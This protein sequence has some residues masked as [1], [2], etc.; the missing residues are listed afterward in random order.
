MVQVTTAPETLRFFQGQI[1]YVK[2][3]GF[4]VH[5]VSS[6][7]RFLDETAERENI[8]TH[9]IEMP[10]SITPLKDLAGLLK[11]YRLFRQLKPALVHS[12]TPKGGLLGTIAARLAGVPVVVY[13][14][15]GLPFTTSRGLKRRLLCLTETIT[16]SL[17]ERV[18]AVS[19][20]NRR[21]AI[22]MGFCA[23]GKIR[24]L[25]SGSC[26]G[27]DAEERFNPQKLPLG[28]REKIRSL[29]GIPPGDSLVLGYVGRIVRDKGIKEL[30]EAWQLLRQEFPKLYLVLVGHEEPQDLVSRDAIRRLEADPRVVFT[31]FLDDLV[32][33]YAAM[34]ILALPTYR[35]G[36]PVA[37]LE[38]AAM[39]L[40]VVATRVDGCV[41][42][43]V[44]GVTG[45]LVP[46]RDSLAL[47]RA[48]ER[49][50]RNPGLRRKMGQA[51]RKRVLRHFQPE[52]I[53]ELLVKEYCSLIPGYFQS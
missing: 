17:A 40:P 11:I 6:P 35:E 28:S 39:Q 1:G 27:V 50:L 23:E 4:I 51:A 21:Q 36:F 41:E 38:G 5:A 43:V 34:D 14:M 18:F 42:A 15:H 52:R 47:A 26:N 20:A 44:D 24:V 48:I 10:R 32:P 33:L 53:C 29:Y 12:H 46:P 7:G 45:F 25:G 8:I 13:T 31:G 2:E 16:C 22:N 9:G 37:P 3:R 30:E 19:L 49:L